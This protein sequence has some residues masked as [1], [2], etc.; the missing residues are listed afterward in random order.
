MVLQDDEL[1]NVNPISINSEKKRRSDQNSLKSNDEEVQI[2]LNSEE[3]KIKTQIKGKNN[4]GDGPSC[5]KSLYSNNL[6][7]FSN[8]SRI[9]Q[10][11]EINQQIKNRRRNNRGRNFLSRNSRLINMHTHS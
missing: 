11:D 3:N 5:N 7:Q 2:E 8:I 1:A 10:L 6:S 4:D 9:S